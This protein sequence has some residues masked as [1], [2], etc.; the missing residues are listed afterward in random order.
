MTTGAALKG[1]Q[2]RAIILDYMFLKRVDGSCTM[3]LIAVR[4]T[5]LNLCWCVSEDRKAVTPYDLLPS[6][7]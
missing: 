6:S 3:R 2:R 7:F 4:A 1:L 5:G